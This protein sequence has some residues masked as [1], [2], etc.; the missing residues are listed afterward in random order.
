VKRWEILALFLLCSAVQG[1]TAPGVRGVRILSTRVDLTSGEREVTFLNDSAADVTAYEIITVNEQPD[2]S[3]S[4]STM[5][6]AL[7]DPEWQVQLKHRPFLPQTPSGGVIRPGQSVT[8]KWNEFGGPSG[9]SSFI[10][11]A[12]IGID[13]AIY[14]DGTA[15]A[16]NSAQL[17][18]FLLTRTQ[19]AVDHETIAAIGRGVLADE[20][21]NETNALKGMRDRLAAEERLGHLR[22]SVA[23]VAT[24]EFTRVILATPDQIFTGTLLEAIVREHG[25]RGDTNQREILKDFVADQDQMAASWRRSAGIRVVNR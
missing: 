12:A 25:L 3:T 19:M 10:S 6:K 16:L 20:A 7:L 17:E 14:S 23:T 24:K 11:H 2:G 4:H 15:E 8:V 1:Q 18:A 9:S 21:N 5:P 13:V 22:S